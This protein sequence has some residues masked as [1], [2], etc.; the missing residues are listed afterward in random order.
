MKRKTQISRDTSI[1]DLISHYPF[2]AHY[3]ATKGI[4]CVACGEPVW[5]TLEEAAMEKGLDDIA[6]NEL[7]NELRIMVLNEENYSRAKINGKLSLPE[8][9]NKICD[10][11]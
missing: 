9:K 6:I 7:I 11:K 3:L 4:R 5:I 1:E 2:V 10:I 8:M